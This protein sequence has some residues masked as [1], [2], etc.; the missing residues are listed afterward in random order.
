MMGNDSSLHETLQP[1]LNRLLAALPPVDEGT[2][3]DQATKTLYTWVEN[4]VNEGD[5]QNMVLN[6]NVGAA[7]ASLENADVVE[8]EEASRRHFIMNRAID[9]CAASL[10]ATLVRHIS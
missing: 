7:D 10:R 3:P 4:T 6:V 8:K 9:E 2:T 5:P 1:V